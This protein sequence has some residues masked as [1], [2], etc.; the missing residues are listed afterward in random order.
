MAAAKLLG[1]SLV[2]DMPIG[3]FQAVRQGQTSTALVPSLYALRA[4]GR[5]TFLRVPQEGPVL[6]PSYLCARASAP[7]WAARRV[8][9]RILSR[10]L[11]D[12]YAANG[13]LI[14]YPACTGRRSGQEADYALC[15]S[16]A[17]L[18]H[19]SHVD[20]YRLYCTKLPSAIEFAY[21]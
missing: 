15:P 3:A 19:L 13:D 17:W 16:A 11:C 6:I 14:V 20:F 5:E 1:E 9:E 18:E 4:D 21:A 2:A 10:E 7:E 8:A 12:F